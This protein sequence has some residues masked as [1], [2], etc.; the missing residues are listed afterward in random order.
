M[1]YICH[2]CGYEIPDGMDFC[3]KCGCM[4]DKATAVDDAGMPVRSCPEC[5]TAAAPFD[6]FCKSCGADLGG[7][8]QPIGLIK[9]QMRRNGAL[10]F[11]LAVIPGFFNIFGLGHFVMKQ[12]ARGVMFLAIS[13]VVWFING[14]AMFSSNIM[15]SVLSIVLFIYQLNDISR[16]IFAPED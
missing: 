16:V 2:D 3:P 10:A 1:R 8:P 4:A 15:I 6:R 9:P 12:W 14:W 13:L 7:I 11:M 5:G